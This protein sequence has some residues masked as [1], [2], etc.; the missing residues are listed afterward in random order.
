VSPFG[1]YP[2]VVQERVRNYGQSNISIR[3]LYLGFAANFLHPF[4]HLSGKYL[5]LML[6]RFINHTPR[7]VAEQRDPVI[8]LGFCSFSQVGVQSK[9]R[10]D[11]PSQT[12]P[13]K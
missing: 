1:R 8:P 4:V 10:P 2:K 3:N 13:E 6:A 11:S 12:A 9:K 7:V 5:L